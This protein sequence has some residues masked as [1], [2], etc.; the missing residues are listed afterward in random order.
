[1]RPPLGCLTLLL[2]A[3]PPSVTAQETVPPAQPETPYTL[4]VKSSLVILDVV[5]TNRNGEV[6]NDLRREDFHIAEDGVAQTI[7][8][9]QPPSEQE[10]PAGEPIH[11]TADLQRRALHAPINIIVLDEINTRFEDM[12]YARYALKKYLNAQP[13]QVQAPTMLIAVSV[14]HLRVLHD[15]TQDRAAILAALDAHLTAYPWQLQSGASSIS[16]LGRSLGALEQVAEATQGHPGHKSLIWVGHGFP[17]LDLSSPNIDSNSAKGINTAVQQA[18][19]MLRDSRI[20]LYTVD[21]TPLSSTVV[22]KTDDNTVLPSLT[23]ATGTDP[24]ADGVQFIQLAKATGGKSFYSRNDVD[25]EI[26]ESVRDGSNFYTIAYRPSSNSDQDHLYRHIQVGFDIPGLRAGYR[27]GYYTRDNGEPQN[28]QQ[29]QVFDISAAVESRLAYTGLDVKA[30]AKSGGTGLYLVG[31]PQQELVWSPEGE[32]EG[33]KLTI[34][35]VAFDSR[36]RILRRVTEDITAHRHMTGSSSPNGLARV[37]VDL[38]ND[39]AAIRL[40]FVVRSN[41][42][43]RIGSAEIPLR[44]APPMRIPR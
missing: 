17:G 12:A 5:V 37:E 9:F 26:G 33:A 3:F 1:M 10:T 29:R 28:P 8:S 32:G 44:D 21:P 39:P 4:N 30:A 31:V 18:V 40:R 24:F 35:A 7:V 43:G 25:R 27:D 41:V 16:Q 11:S 15:Y 22:V 19:N 13:A 6:R 2:L 20:T 23:D 14:D 38:P 34:V 42:D 36:G